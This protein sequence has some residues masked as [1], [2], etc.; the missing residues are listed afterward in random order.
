MHWR[1]SCYLKPEGSCR[2]TK[3]WEASRPGH[4]LPSVGSCGKIMENPFHRFPHCYGQAD[5]IF[6]DLLLTIF[7]PY[8]SRFRI[9]STRST[10]GQP[11]LPMIQRIEPKE[12][13]RMVRTKNHAQEETLWSAL[14]SSLERNQPLEVQR[15]EVPYCV[16]NVRDVQKKASIWS[17]LWVRFSFPSDKFPLTV[18]PFGHT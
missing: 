11:S 4:P 9:E 16:G 14:F 2:H 10:L 7:S 15:F 3:S 13:S 12:H 6:H 5:V 1:E 18:R 17:P 8:P